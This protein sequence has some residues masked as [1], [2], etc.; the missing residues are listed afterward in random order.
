[1]DILLRESKVNRNKSQMWIIT[2]PQTTGYMHYTKVFDTLRPSC[3]RLV[4][5]QE[6]HEDGGEHIHAALETVHGITKSRL[7][8]EMIKLWPERANLNVQK[9]KCF[10]CVWNYC[11]K[12]GTFSMYGTEPV[13]K[14]GNTKRKI[15]MSQLEHEKHM[16]DWIHELFLKENEM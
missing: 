5:C 1:M 12:D 6:L 9:A 16:S 2:W 13:C 8:K 11:K 3:S 14:R 4:V 10:H 15:P 7:I